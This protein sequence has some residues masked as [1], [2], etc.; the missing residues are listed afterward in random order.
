M[1][2][3]TTLGIVGE[4]GS[5]KTTL[6]RIIAGL[7]RADDGHILIDGNV[8]PP[9]TRSDHVQYVFQDPYSSLDP[10]ISIVNTVAEPL[11]ARGFAKLK[12]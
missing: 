2:S 8:R 1:K 12:L 4:S 5:G 11:L 3:G 6:A 9:R 10:R 7:E